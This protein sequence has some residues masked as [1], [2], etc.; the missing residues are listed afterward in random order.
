MYSINFFN[1]TTAAIDE[2]GQSWVYIC[3]L[4]STLLYGELPETCI[5]ICFQARQ[6]ER[7]ESVAKT[8][9]HL[10]MDGLNFSKLL[11]DNQNF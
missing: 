2:I 1:Q 6:Q 5:Q 8:Y 10:S 9:C 11:S 4:P 3:P 7:R